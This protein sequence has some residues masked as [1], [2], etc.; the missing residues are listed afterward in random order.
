M[1]PVS[2]WIPMRW[3]S[4]PLEI[5]R[6]QKKDGFSAELKGALESWHTPAALGFLKGSPVSCLVVSWAAGLPEDAEQQKSLGPLME[7]GRHQGLS[8]AGLITDSADKRAAM[9]AAGKAGLQAVLAEGDLPKGDLPVIPLAEVTS[10]PWGSV[11]AVVALT[12]SRWPCVQGEGDAREATDVNASPTRA[13]WIDSNIFLLQLVR[14]YAPRTPIWLMFEA[15][16]DVALAPAAYLR[17]VA[18]TGAAGA[19]WAVSLG[20]KIRAGLANNSPEAVRTWNQISGAL[21]FFAKHRDWALSRPKAALG[22]VS[23]FAGNN[24]MLGEETL[25]LLARRTVPFRVVLRSALATTDLT[26][27]KAVICLDEEPPGG[28]ARQRLLSFVKQGGLLLACEKWGKE[29]TPAPGA[30]HPRF[31]V[32]LL[33]Q[34]RLAVSREKSPDPFLVAR[35]A[36]L[37]LDRVNDLLRF[38]NISTAICRLTSAG[39]GKQDLLQ[40]VNFARRDPAD[41]IPIWL[42][43]P[44]KAARLWS[45]E[46][47][48]PT[49][50][51]V[52]PELGGATIQVPSIAVYAA[53]ELS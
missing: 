21:A 41:G 26:G 23:D 13:A 16:D 40:F 4:G 48:S 53:L 50:V 24:Q 35:D 47:D 6:R 22:V 31:D 45:F 8:F 29:G 49:T 27:L 30:S 38:Y 20:L 10:A 11:P 36:H 18:D 3:P 7:A 12:G 19:Q 5:S 17:A 14:A 44:C 32:R 1:D 25:N 9:Q 15:P 28:T 34:G 46:D 43:D 39:D 33:G 52:S 37:L 2:S 51:R 42:R